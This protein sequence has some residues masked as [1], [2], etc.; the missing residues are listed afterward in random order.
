MEFDSASQLVNASATA[1]H[2]GVENHV[3]ASNIIAQSMAAGKCFSVSGDS[4]RMPT[5]FIPVLHCIAL[6]CLASHLQGLC[7]RA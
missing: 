2:V 5:C 1:L 7:K 6:H 4:C 3:H